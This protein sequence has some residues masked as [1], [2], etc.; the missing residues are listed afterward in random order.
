M[1]CSPNSRQL[2]IWV[3]SV[4]YSSNPRKILHHQSEDGIAVLLENDFAGFALAHFLQ[5]LLT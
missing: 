1:L 2:Q 4:N 5:Y 3:N